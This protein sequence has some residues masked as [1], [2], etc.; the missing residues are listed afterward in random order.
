MAPVYP[1][2]LA[3]RRPWL[4][5]RTTSPAAVT[6]RGPAL[7]DIAV[8]GTGC[9]SLASTAQRRTFQSSTTCPPLRTT[10]TCSPVVHETDWI[11]AAPEAAAVQATAPVR[12]STTE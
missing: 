10:A 12:T 9:S 4:H 8:I 11:P 3:S 6:T 1:V 5:T 7:L 2:K